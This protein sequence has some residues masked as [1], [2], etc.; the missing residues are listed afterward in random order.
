[1]T[2]TAEHLR[3]TLDGRWRD[4]KNRLREQLA[5]EVFRPHYTPNTV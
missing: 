3:N 5:S 4:V 1:M 2:T